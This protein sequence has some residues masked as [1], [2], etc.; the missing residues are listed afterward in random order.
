[1]TVLACND[2]RTN[3]DLIADVAKLGY[4]DG[5]VL[6]VTP[7]AGGWWTKWM[8]EVL[9]SSTADFRSLPYLDDE[10]DTVCFDPPYVALGG[11]KTTGKEMTGMYERFGQLD[12][13]STPEKLQQLIDAGLN[14]CLRVARRYV[15][16]KCQ[17]YVSGGKLWPGVYFTTA[18]SYFGR[19]AKLVDVFHMYTRTPRPQPHG[20]TQRHARRNLST[21][22]VFK[23]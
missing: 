10:W 20:R 14:E 21:L 19:Y 17:D 3:G 9:G 15:L 13:P 2:W 12:C 7:G 22:L 4:L 1:M 18:E 6:D 8:P 11:R 23:P 5:T 16:V